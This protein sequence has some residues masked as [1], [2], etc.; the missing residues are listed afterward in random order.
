MDQVL[1]KRS[2]AASDVRCSVCGQGFLVYWEN[3]SRSERTASRTQIQD[4]LREH[5]AQHFAEGEAHEAHPKDGFHL[6]EWVVSSKYSAASPVAGEE[7][8]GV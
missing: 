1:C 2:N 5:H 3:L 6:P 4:L 7:V 8:Q